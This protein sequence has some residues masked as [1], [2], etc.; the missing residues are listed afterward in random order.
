MVTYVFQHAVELYKLLLSTG[1]DSG[2]VN[3][4]MYCLDTLRVERGLPCWGNE[5][6]THTTPLEVGQDHTLHMDKVQ[7][8]SKVCDSLHLLTEH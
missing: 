2:V 7:L 5:L 6:G 8:S 4:G 1:A 3:A